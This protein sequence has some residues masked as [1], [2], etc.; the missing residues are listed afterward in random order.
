MFSETVD[1]LVSALSDVFIIASYYLTQGFDVVFS[2][3]IVSHETV[4]FVGM[5]LVVVFKDVFTKAFKKRNDIPT[6]IVS[7]L[8]WYKRTYPPENLWLFVKAFNKFINSFFADFFIANLYFQIRSKL[9][10]SCKIAENHLKE[11]VYC[12]HAEPV[13]VVKKQMKSRVR[14]IDNNVFGQSCHAFDGRQVWLR[15]VESPWNT[16]KLTYDSHFHFLS[17]FVCKRHCQYVFILVRV[18]Y[19]QGDIFR[20]QSESLT[21]TCTGFIYS[22][23]GRG[24]YHSSTAL[25]IQYF[26][27]HNA[28]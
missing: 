19:K 21:R 15:V 1:Y 16:I 4:Q 27:Y 26:I 6:L 9:Q 11:T 22:K 18:A 14:I 28:D 20:C 17:S 13:V 2:E 12:L 7:Y 24:L 23:I 3:F 25:F 10:F 5:F 8:L